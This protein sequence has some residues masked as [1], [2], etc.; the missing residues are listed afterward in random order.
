[1]LQACRQPLAQWDPSLQP[2]QACLDGGGWACAPS[3]QPHWPRRYHSRVRGSAWVWS[4]CWEGLMLVA[5]Q[6]RN[7]AVFLARLWLSFPLAPRGPGSTHSRVG[8]GGGCAHPAGGSVVQRAPLVLALA[9]PTLAPWLCL[10]ETQAGGSAVREG[11]VLLPC[12]ICPWAPA[13]HW[14]VA[15][16]HHCKGVSRG[17]HSSP[18]PN[19]RQPHPTPS[20]ACF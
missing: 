17:K 18:G 9:C 19:N 5:N 1:M 6:C 4:H 14:E 13:L 8:C 11:R 16:C 20:P 2:Q 15:M 12:T 3:D 7:K 10:P